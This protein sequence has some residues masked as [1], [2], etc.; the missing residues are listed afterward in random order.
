MHMVKIKTCP[1][2]A[3]RVFVDVPYTARQFY[4]FANLKE[5]VWKISLE[6]R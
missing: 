5:Q 1:C 2:S 4:H 6:L 3:G